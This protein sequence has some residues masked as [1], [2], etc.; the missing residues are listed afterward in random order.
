MWTLATD[1]DDDD[2]DA[3][4][5]NAGYPDMIPRADTI[6]DMYA[7]SAVSG[8][9]AHRSVRNTWQRHSNHSHRVADGT[10]L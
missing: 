4:A 10:P 3:D 5:M 2:D 1:D 9:W 7:G 6:M 8:Q